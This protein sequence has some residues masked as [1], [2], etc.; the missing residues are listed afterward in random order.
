[1]MI[2]GATLLLA[3]SASAFPLGRSI[4]NTLGGIISGKNKLTFNA[5][6]NFKVSFSLFFSP[7]DIEGVRSCL[8]PIC[9]WGN[10]QVRSRSD[11]QLFMVKLTGTSIILHW[12]GT[13][14]GRRGGLLMYV[15]LLQPPFPT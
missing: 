9:T 7:Q 4:S 14:V 2:L 13:E 10:D 1:M 5:A 3:S 12:Q 15:T 6:G 8:S 11:S